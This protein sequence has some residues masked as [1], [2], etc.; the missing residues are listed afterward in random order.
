MSQIKAKA[1]LTGYVL[2][3][4]FTDGIGETDNPAALA[5]FADA[6]DYT[7]QTVKPAEPEPAADPDAK[8]KK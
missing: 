1:R 4:E 7:I 6:A 5:F 8:P 2:G 3:V